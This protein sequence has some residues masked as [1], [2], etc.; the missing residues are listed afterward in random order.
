M[1]KTLLLAAALAC[2][3]VAA[4]EKEVWACQGVDANGFK[5]ENRKWERVAYAPDNWLL[6]L[7]RIDAINVD[8]NIKSGEQD[9]SLRCTDLVI[10]TCT[11]STGIYVSFD[12][13]TGAGSVASTSGSAYPNSDE[14]RDSIYIEPIQCTKF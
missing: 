3:G 1:K 12:R 11:S 7:D 5:W 2:S 13:A 9:Y 8:G 6:S 10:L 4:Q 14:S